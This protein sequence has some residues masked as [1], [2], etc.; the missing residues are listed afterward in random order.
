[1]TLLAAVA[2][3]LCLSL[4]LAAQS[5]TDSSLTSTIDRLFDA[6]KRSDTAA[7]RALFLAGGRVITP[8]PPNAPPDRVTALAVDDFV[9]FVGNNPPGSWIERAWNP[10]TSVSEG[11]GHVWFD[12]DI[13]RNGSRTQCGSNS[14][15]LQRVGAAWKIVSMAFSAKTVGCASHPPPS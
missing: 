15:Q 9:K 5:T 4:P 2:T 8:P 3:S 13:Y 1:V 12:Y 14:A 11:L 7:V 6:M 10:V